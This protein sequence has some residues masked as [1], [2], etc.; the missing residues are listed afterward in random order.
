MYVHV[1]A[2]LLRD[3]RGVCATDERLLPLCRFVGPYATGDSLVRFASHC[4]RRRSICRQSVSR[5]QPN[6][7]QAAEIFLVERRR[8]RQRCAAVVD[9]AVVVSPLVRVRQASSSAVNARRSGQSFA[10][11]ASLKYW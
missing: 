8:R 3:K 1:D 2:P 7:D 9:V 5:L 11:D 10:G 6:G 4:S